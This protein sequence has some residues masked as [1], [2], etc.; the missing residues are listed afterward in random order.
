LKDVSV[1]FAD[2]G[3]ALP[4]LSFGFWN[5]SLASFFALADFPMAESGDEIWKNRVELNS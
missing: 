4:T 1:K 5:D 3:F 2:L